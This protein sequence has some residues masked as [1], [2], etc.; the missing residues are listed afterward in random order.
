MTLKE[1]VEAW[2]LILQADRYE[3]KLPLFLWR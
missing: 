1:R 3:K 2:K